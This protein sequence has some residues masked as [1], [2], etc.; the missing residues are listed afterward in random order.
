MPGN[1]PRPICLFFD[2]KKCMLCGQSSYFL[3]NEHNLAKYLARILIVWVVDERSRGAPD[4]AVSLTART[5][6]AEF[7]LKA[8]RECSI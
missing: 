5:G 7:A 2:L 1:P 8:P 6:R 4:G 3:C